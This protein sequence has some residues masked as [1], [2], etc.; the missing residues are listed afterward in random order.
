MPAPNAGMKASETE[1][2]KSPGW[3]LWDLVSGFILSVFLN[4]K[5]ESKRE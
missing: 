2:K 4:V 5:F 3:G 1:E